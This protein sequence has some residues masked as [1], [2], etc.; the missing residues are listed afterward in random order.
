VLVA[1]HLNEK[2][3]E[4][5]CPSRFGLVT[6]A[7]QKTPQ[8][9]KLTRFAADCLSHGCWQNR[10]RKKRIRCTIVAIVT[11]MFSERRF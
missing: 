9:R 1:G 3:G 6:I 7:K 2:Y 4:V 11:G 10:D 5:M 8:V